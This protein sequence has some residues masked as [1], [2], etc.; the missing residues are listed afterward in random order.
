MNDKFLY[1]DVIPINSYKRTVWFITENYPTIKKEY[2]A[3]WHSEAKIE[4]VVQAW[5]TIQVGLGTKINFTVQ[6]FDVGIVEIE[7][8]VHSMM[9]GRMVN[10]NFEME[11]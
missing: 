10:Q 2:L 6:A 1:K 3:V 11:V 8:V 5:K 9:N 7:K 4:D